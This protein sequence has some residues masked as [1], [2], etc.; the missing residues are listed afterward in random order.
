MQQIYEYIIDEAGNKSKHRQIADGITQAIADKVVKPGDMLPSVNS[1]LNK[2]PVARMTLVKALDELKER[3]IIESENRIG[4]FVKS[5]NVRQKLKVLLFLTSFNVYHEI[6]YNEIIT[7]LKNEEITVDLY[8]HHCNPMV[9][10][11]VLNENRGLYG[12]YVVTPF[13]NPQV[14]KSL[15]DIPIKK[16]LQVIR[17]P[18]IEDTSYISQNFY[19]ELMD[20]I[21]GVKDRISK[22]KKFILV[23]PEKGG[24]PEII[25]QAFFNFCT[26][27]G[28]NFGEVPHIKKEIVKENQAY[29]VIADTDLIELVKFGEE[30]GFKLGRSIGILS[31]NDTPMKEI[32]RS[33]ITVISTDF[34]EMGRSVSDFIKTRQPVQKIIPT[35]IKLRNSL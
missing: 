4:Y 16:L 17:P 23:F 1:I 9:F 2:L 14:K 12:L 18:V 5:G 32:I 24:H 26:N 27:S 31:Y 6:L 22:Y 28:I 20:A 7:D 15:T 11:S 3:G 10:R 35:T 19:E 33:G 13:N 30:K 21:K 25:R 29:F 34:A 8:F